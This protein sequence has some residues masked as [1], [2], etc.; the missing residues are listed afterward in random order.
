MLLMVAMWV[1]RACIPGLWGACTRALAHG[2][3]QWSMVGLPRVG[4][5][6]LA[7]VKSATSALSMWTCRRENLPM[8]L[9]PAQQR[10]M[11]RVV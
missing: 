2:T 10:R 9:A 8:P 5:C 6:P 4:G 11:A 7:L 3:P 1:P